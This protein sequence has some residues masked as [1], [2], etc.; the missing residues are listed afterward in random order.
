MQVSVKEKEITSVEP[1]RKEQG[2]ESVLY[3]C[4]N[5]SISISVHPMFNKIM[6]TTQFVQFLSPQ[7]D[8]SKRKR[9]CPSGSE[10]QITAK[11]NK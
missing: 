7:R 6:G 11:Q 3:T 8:K 1:L 9:Y 10:R 4:L 5:K 2:A